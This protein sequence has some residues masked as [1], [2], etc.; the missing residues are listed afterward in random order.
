MKK[1][2]IC[3]A[4]KPDEEFPEVVR[5]SKDVS[6]H[7]CTVCAKKKGLLSALMWREATKKEK[8]CPRCKQVKPD[9][10]FR[11]CAKTS[12]GLDTYCIECSRL[13]GKEQ[14]RKRSNLNK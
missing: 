7:V 6:D 12:D 11:I 1:C 4:Y 13:F 9:L 8:F 14:Y 3:L 10:A 5:R 2:R